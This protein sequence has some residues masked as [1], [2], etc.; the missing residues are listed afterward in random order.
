MTIA[1]LGWIGLRRQFKIELLP[2]YNGL[3]RVPNAT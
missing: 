1:S 2:R 3:L